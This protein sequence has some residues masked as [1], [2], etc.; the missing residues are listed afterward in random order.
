MNS[1]NI[2]T[3]RRRPADREVPVYVTDR[4][5]LCVARTVGL[6]LP[7]AGDAAARLRVGNDPTRALGLPIGGRIDLE[8]PLRRDPEYW[9]R[10]EELS[11]LR[12]AGALYTNGNR[13]IARVEVELAPWSHEVSELSL[14]PAVN[15]PH[16][17]GARRTR[18]WF[19]FA[20]A[21][22]DQLRADL[23]AR[24]TPDELIELDDA[25]CS[26]RERVAV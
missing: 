16:R 21:A 26:E 25:S 14:R 11:A 12:T 7:I 3:P 17:W 15:R 4:A 22:A 18:A 1:K 19:A 5:Q 8:L 20:H 6:P 13:R 2:A 24:A 10:S 9:G 23:L